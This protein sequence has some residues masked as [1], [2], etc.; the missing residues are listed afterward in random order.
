MSEAEERRRQVELR[1]AVLRDLVPTELMLPGE[2]NPVTI[3][4][5][6]GMDA[7]PSR[8]V[9]PGLDELG[10]VLGEATVALVRS[11]CE[12]WTRWLVRWSV[13]AGA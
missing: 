11:Y 1:R 7:D 5:Q 8:V 6:I 4:V 12:V 2:R 9:A 10:A 13:E 3:C